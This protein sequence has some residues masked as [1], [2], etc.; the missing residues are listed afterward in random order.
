MYIG[1]NKKIN[2]KLDSDT[3]KRKSNDQ[4]N[5]PRHLPAPKARIWY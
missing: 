3:P 1:R 2:S 4:R 5:A